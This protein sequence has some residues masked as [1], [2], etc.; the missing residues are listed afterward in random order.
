MN[1]AADDSGP[2][3]AGV[4]ALVAAAW[5]A[6]DAPLSVAAIYLAIRAGL[7]GADGVLSPAIASAKLAGWVGVLVALGWAAWRTELTVRRPREIVLEGGFVAVT[8]AVPVGLA[9]WGGNEG[10]SWLWLA[11]EWAKI[12]ANFVLLHRLTPWLGWAG[13]ALFALH[14]AFAVGARGSRALGYVTTIAPLAIAVTLVVWLS[15]I[16]AGAR[17][18]VYL[19]AYVLPWGVTVVGLVRGRARLAA[20]AAAIGVTMGGLLVHYL[21]VLPFGHADFAARPGVTKIY[22]AAGAAPDVPLAFLRDFELDSSRNAIYSAYGPTSG[23]LRLDLA[24][25]V[26]TPIEVGN[27]LVR[28]LRPSPDPTRLLA[29]DWVLGTMLRIT[30]DPFAIEDRAI[31][32]KGPGR[33][34]PMS[35]VV[36]AESAYVVYTELPG[37]A[38]VDLAG[39]EITRR[40]SF[41]D[42]GLTRYRSGAWEAVGDAAQRFLVVELGAVDAAGHYL[43]VRVDLDSFTVVAKQEVPDGGLA[44]LW[45]P[46]RNAIFTAGF[47]TDRIFEFDATTL[48]PRRTLVGPLNVRAMAYDARRD[49]LL[50]I[51]FLPG[52]LWAIRYADE[53]VL[54]RERVGNKSMS[55]ALDS[56]GDRLYLGSEDGV[57]R[58]DLATFLGAARG[59]HTAAITPGEEGRPP[60]S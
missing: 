4:S 49:L 19:I 36:G 30:K 7:H 47:F 23:I 38:E 50:A 26:L 33:S 12:P 37:M 1:A 18:V 41:R 6:I 32:L 53:A 35:F 45:V 27:G 44:I 48:A 22:P 34:V 59:G 10:I 51:A 5:L 13:A 21:G 8:I 29:L 39:G 14:V 57:F 17:I 42:Q 31:R 3:R 20:R 55:L 2:S 15:R 46:E 25:A 56:A 9:I 60:R 40:L 54:A 58:V 24:T 16:T 43:L 52:E 28:H 11:Q